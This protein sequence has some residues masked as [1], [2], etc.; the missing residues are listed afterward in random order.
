M[1]VPIA[2]AR[3]LGM[4]P[5]NHTIF[6]VPES[7]LAPQEVRSNERLESRLAAQEIRFNAKLEKLEGRF[8]QKLDELT[9]TLDKFL[10]RVTDVEEE[11]IFLKEDLRRVKAVIR[12]KLGVSLD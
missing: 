8:M 3:I 12:E 2:I 11:F 6:F 9:T 1:R 5:V 10:K 4:I 7:R